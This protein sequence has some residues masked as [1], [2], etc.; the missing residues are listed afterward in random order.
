MGAVGSTF[1]S[2]I[3]ELT[4]AEFSSSYGTSIGCFFVSAKEIEFLLIFAIR[5]FTVNE[6][7]IVDS[8]DVSDSL[9]GVTGFSGEVFC[10][11]LTFD[12][13]LDRIGGVVDGFEDNLEGE[14]DFDGVEVFELGFDVLEAGEGDSF[15]TAGFPNKTDL[16]NEDD[17]RLTGTCTAA[18]LASFSFSFN[19]AILSFT[20]KTGSS[21]MIKSIIGS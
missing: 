1:C 4:F 16:I 11:F 6:T 9:L 15:G 14:I 17:V 18:A 7:L 13:G 3:V 21:A 5:S 8:V 19:N 10:P 2:F 12:E 20:V